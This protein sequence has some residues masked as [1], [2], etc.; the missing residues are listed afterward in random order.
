MSEQEHRL[1]VVELESERTIAELGYDPRPLMPLVRE[2]ARSHPS[3]TA[4]DIVAVLKAEN[5]DAFKPR[6]ATVRAQPT[7][8][9]AGMSESEKIEFID[10]HGLEKFQGL[11]REQSVRTRAEMQRKIRGF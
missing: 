7:M 1:R 10:K 4:T 11:V 6:E 8:G 2:E 5:P 3:F 9:L